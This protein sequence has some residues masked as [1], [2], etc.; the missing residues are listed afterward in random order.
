LKQKT[1][2]SVTTPLQNPLI[3]LKICVS[4]QFE[5]RISDCRASFWEDS[6]TV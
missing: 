3:N 4:R 5:K 2:Q 6:V 1:S